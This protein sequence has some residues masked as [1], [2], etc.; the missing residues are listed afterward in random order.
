M[1]D[2]VNSGSPVGKAERGGRSAGDRPRDA[3]LHLG[4]IVKTMFS[5]S[6]DDRELEIMARCFNTAL[7]QITIRMATYFLP[8]WLPLPHQRAAQEAVA[9]LEQMIYRIIHERRESGQDPDDLL[10]MLLSARDEETGEGM[11]DLEIRDE[12]MVTLFGGYEATADALTWT[13]YLLGEHPAVDET[14]Q[15]EIESVIG[16]RTPTFEDLVRL[17]L[18]H[19]PGLPGVDASLSALL[20]L[21]PHRARRGR[22]QRLPHSG[23]GPDADRPLRHHR[24]PDLGRC[25]SLPSRTL[26]A[27]PGRGPAAQRLRPLRHRAADVYRPPPRPSRDAAHPGRGGAALPATPRPRLVRGP[28]GGHLTAGQGR[29]VDDSGSRVT[30]QTAS[31][32]LTSP[33]SPG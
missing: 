1:T 2:V 16:N 29:D 12:V 28:Q 8:E 5:L 30:G 33:S 23:R 31:S 17:H 26:R 14:M 22:D 9:T 25:R 4:I 15:G 10:S 6:I 18:T 3:V 27:F 20:V 13:W 7:E 19:F 24:H 32:R 11:T 21:Q